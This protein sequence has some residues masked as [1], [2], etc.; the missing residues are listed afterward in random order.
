MERRQEFTAIKGEREVI[1]K[2][3]DNLKLEGDFDRP[4]LRAILPAERPKPVKPIDNLRP[5]GEFFGERITTQVTKG[6][7]AEIHRHVD[8]LRTEGTFT[9][10]H[11]R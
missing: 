8:N 7:R 9:G 3:L 2:P 1:Q 11:T 6:E 10:M 4:E 5:E